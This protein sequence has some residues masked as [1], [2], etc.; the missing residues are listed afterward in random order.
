[1]KILAGS[2][3]PGLAKRISEYLDHPLAEVQLSRFPDGE[4]F[5]QV[6]ENI[7]GNDVFIVQPT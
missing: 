3:H 6:T 2:S 1:M 7:R 4:I 5:I